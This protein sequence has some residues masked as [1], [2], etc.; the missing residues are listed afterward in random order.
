[1]KKKLRLG[2][3]G[4]GVAA[5]RLY[6]PAFEQVA[7]RIE[8]VACANRTRSKAVRFAKRAGIARV[9]SDAEALLSA[10]DVDAVLIS[11]PIDALPSYVLAS[12]RAGKA[13]LS[14]KPI[15][16]SVKL[17]Q[18]LLKKAE[19]LEPV[20]MVGENYAFF[21]LVAKLKEWIGSGR[22][23]AVRLVEARMFN[24]LDRRNPYVRTPWR[25][26]PEHPGGFITDAGVHLAHV[27][28]T[29][30]GSPV[31][32]K[33]LTACFDPKL[34]PI[35]TALAVM[36][37]GD[38]VLG[39]WTSCFTAHAQTPMLIVYGSRGT[40]EFS[41]DRLS[42]RSARGKVQ[43]VESE[44]NSFAAQFRHFADVVT[45]GASPRITPRDALADLAMVEAIVA[46]HRH[47]AA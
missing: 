37:F 32:V 3:L 7:T 9:E 18:A 35:D 39:T 11:L 4:T 24:W 36:Q 19:K 40:A 13:V 10:D 15:A 43:L 23:G 21:P 30:F 45:E 22:L 17:G 20:W 5:E 42:F 28:R 14:E 33:S 44:A 25:A 16:A 29:C 6:L 12:L 8:W 47:P 41:P 31:E 38:G 46:G 2:L 26:A 27:V 1:M 34:P